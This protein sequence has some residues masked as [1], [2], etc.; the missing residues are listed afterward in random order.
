MEN[1]QTTQVSLKN[2]FTKRMDMRKIVDNT[3]LCRTCLA[4]GGDVKLVDLN[5]PIQKTNLEEKKGVTHMDCLIYCMHFTNAPGMP[6]A[7]CGNCS[8]TL[9]I[10]YAFMK[11]AF[12]AQEILKRKL[13]GMRK[14]KYIRQRK[15][16]GENQQCPSVES[17]KEK[18]FR[19]KVCDVKL[20]GRIS[21]KKHVK[22]HLDLIVYKCQLCPH[23]SRGRLCLSE[24]YLLAHNLTASAE[25]LKPK[26]LSSLEI[27][28]QRCVHDNPQINENT[29][30]HS[31]TA[32]KP[33]LASI[34][35]NE[36]HRCLNKKMLTENGPL[37]QENLGDQAASSNCDS[38]LENK[39]KLNKPMSLQLAQNDVAQMDVDDLIVEESVNSS[40][41]MLVFSL[42]DTEYSATGGKYVAN[43]DH[44]M[45][46]NIKCKTCIKSFSTQRELKAHMLSHNE[47][48]HFFCDNCTFYTFFKEDLHQH[49]RSRH[50]I[51][52][53]SPQLQP[54]NKQFKEVRQSNRNREET[55]RHDFC[56]VKSSSKLQ[57]KHHYFENHSIH[58]NEIH[59]TPKIVDSLMNAPIQFTLIVQNT[60]KRL[61]TTKFNCPKDISPD[62]KEIV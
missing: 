45:V 48:P 12:R 1:C 36:V 62:C 54:K 18:Q 61:P 8:S 28:K 14:M 21:L 57:F 46:N 15:Q 20:K 22:L 31:T 49:Y 40:E 30:R 51:Q 39:V 32:S 23:E 2:I 33:M 6:A 17:K 27:Q 58:A 4:V 26:P 16:G 25:Q 3:L 35:T 10:V 29:E 47:L 44:K 19:C 24:H 59:V 37:K 41:E 11:N 60:A 9:K 13:Q 53:T 43:A 38:I 42:G 55:N 50:N 56:V 5:D 7:I 52:P 34:S